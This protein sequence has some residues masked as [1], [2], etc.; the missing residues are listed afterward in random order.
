MFSILSLK[1]GSY[2]LSTVNTRRSS[3][4]QRCTSHRLLV[5]KPTQAGRAPAHGAPAKDGVGASAHIPTPST[6]PADRRV[7]TLAPW[8]GKQD[9]C[10]SLGR[11]ASGSGP[12]TAQARHP[13]S[14]SVTPSSAPFPCCHLFPPHPGSSLQR[15]LPAALPEKGPQRPVFLALSQTRLAGPQPPAFPLLQHRPAQRPY[16][17]HSFSSTVPSDWKTR[18]P[19]SHAASAPSLVPSSDGLSGS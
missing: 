13:A 12:T 14:S 10:L 6:G 2:T 3:S 11:A 1:T 4:G 18:L 15:L 19:L 8:R 16:H 7:G 17:L 5:E 9:S